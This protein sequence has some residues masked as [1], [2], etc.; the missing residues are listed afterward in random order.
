MR[1]PELH[2]GREMRK[3]LVFCAILGAC[4]IASRVVIPVRASVPDAIITVD[5][6]SQ[7]SLFPPDIIAPL[8]QWR[9]SSER[10]TI[11]RIEIPFADGS[12]KVELWSEGEK[13]H[14]RELDTN[15]VG[16]V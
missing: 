4:V 8:F 3:V 1:I 16:F 11:W 10:A 15:L 6:P 5:Y 7:G 9:D 2:R 12:P 13:F 14:V